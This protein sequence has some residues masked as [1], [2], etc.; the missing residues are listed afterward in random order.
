MITTVSSIMEKDFITIESMDSVD[1]ARQ[2]MAQNRIG[3]LPVM[4]NGHL[5]G[6][7]RRR[8]VSTAP[9]RGGCWAPQQA[10]LIFSVHAGQ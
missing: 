2:I 3:C 6:I 10:L 1:N 9:I 4:E 8:R 5:V 7:R